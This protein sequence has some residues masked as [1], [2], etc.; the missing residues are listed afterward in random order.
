[1]WS[2]SRTWPKK[3]TPNTGRGSASARNSGTTSQ[4]ESPATVQIPPAKPDRTRAASDARSLASAARSSSVRAGSVNSRPNAPSPGSRRTS[5]GTNLSL[6]QLSGSVTESWE[7]T[8]SGRAPRN[9][10]RPATGVLRRSVRSPRLT[11]ARHRVAGKNGRTALS[12]PRERPAS[13]A[14]TMR[15]PVLVH[16]TSPAPAGWR[17]RVAGGAE[18]PLLAR[19]I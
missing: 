16:S 3:P 18:E 15:R 13:L 5:N 1:M 19:R 7:S 9:L 8:A 4:C 10:E 17:T 11:S 2:T 12:H 14:P 6:G